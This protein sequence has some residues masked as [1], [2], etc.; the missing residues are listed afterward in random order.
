[1]SSIGEKVAKLRAE[2][3]WTLVELAM[4]SGVSKSHISAIENN[5]RPHPSIQQVMKLARAFSV[6]LAFFDD[7]DTMSAT[8]EVSQTVGTQR[9]LPKGKSNLVDQFLELYDVETQRF[10]VSEDSKPYVA[11]A[12]QLAERGTIHDASTLLQLIAQFMRERQ[13]P[14]ESK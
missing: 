4:I 10:I 7:D 5:T 11:L 9:D 6:P 2:H 1:M 14:Y 8:S 13:Q 3:G 12:K